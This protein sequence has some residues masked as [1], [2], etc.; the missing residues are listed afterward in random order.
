MSLVG[1]RPESYDFVAHYPDAYAEITQVRPGLMGLSQLAFAG[2]SAILDPKD[3]LDHYVE[4][5]LPQK[6]MLDRLYAARW[7]L[8]L[9]VRIVLWTVVAVVFNRPVAVDRSTGRMNLRRR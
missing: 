4:S 2:E 1:P 6:V 7:S 8:W 3:P 5:I 9:D